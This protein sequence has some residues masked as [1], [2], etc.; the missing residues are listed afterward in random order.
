MRMVAAVNTLVKTVYKGAYRD[1]GYKTVGRKT[2]LPT[3]DP[4]CKHVKFLCP[5]D[6]LSGDET[7]WKCPI[8]K[9]S[10]KP[11][12]KNMNMNKSSP[13]Y[14]YGSNVMFAGYFGKGSDFDSSGARR[15]GRNQGGR[16]MSNSSRSSKG[17]KGKGGKGS[18]SNR[19]LTWAPPMG[20]IMNMMRTKKMSTNG[21]P[22]KA[23]A[24]VAFL[25]SFHPQCV[26]QGPPSKPTAP[27][28]SI[29]APSPSY[30]PTRC[31]DET[32]L[33]F[34]DFESGS[35]PEW[36]IN[37]VESSGGFTSFLGRLGPKD[38]TS[39]KFF[40]IPVASSL[41]I[42][43]DFYEIDN[44][45]DPTD[46]FF[47]YISDQK[48]DFGNFKASAD[49]GKKRGKTDCG[50]TWTMESK[51]SPK[52]IGFRND[53][54]R[55]RR[56]QIHRVVAIVPSSCSVYNNGILSI[57]FEALT[58][59]SVNN[60]AAG[61]DNLRI[62]AQNPCGDTPAP[63]SGGSPEGTPM[64]TSV[65]G[66]SIRTDEPTG[67]PTESPTG[68]PTMVPTASPTSMPT[69]SPTASP[70]S[71]PTGSPTSSPTLNP[72][73][74][75]TSS[76]TVSPTALPTMS[77]TTSPITSPTESPTADPTA[78]PTKSPT[79]SPTSS[80]TASPTSSPTNSPTGSPTSSPTEIPRNAA[81]TGMV[82]DNEDNPIEGAI[83]VLL[84][85]SGSVINVAT[86][87]EDGTYLFEDLPAGDY[88][89][90]ETNPVLYPL[91][92]DDYDF[93]PDGDVADSDRT[94]D[95]EI[96]VT[97]TPG[98]LDADNDF[99]DSKLEDPPTPSTST[100]PPTGSPTASPTLFP[101][102]SPTAFPTASPTSS[103]TELLRNAA[104][105]GI[106][107]DDEGKPLAGAII[108]LLDE[109][110]SV[111]NAATTSKDGTYLFEDLPAGEY[112]VRETNPVLYPLN[113]DDYDFDPDGDV[114]DSDRT[115]DNK[116]AVTLTPGELDAENDFV[117]S[118]GDETGP[119][120]PEQRLSQALLPVRLNSCPYFVTIASNYDQ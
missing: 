81:I 61:V 4:A 99:V 103:P 47:A 88:T 109:S 2:V 16:R 35:A 39:K 79:A 113:V 96:A 9:A 84:N 45:E 87:T 30:E 106:V 65:P 27:T 48:L 44:W 59:E 34:E 116:I 33:I 42:S 90:R 86:T 12:S 104:I 57:A 108:V 31:V 73:A 120:V 19:A 117:D 14:G 6:S 40:N 53:D 58:N 52:Q 18:R 17:S 69:S 70:T 7:L 8:K 32:L 63:F 98:E 38:L 3:S 82:R 112:T 75:P 25:P 78:S 111:I 102:V 91:N 5:G 110:G 1:V 54:N 23:G 72:T 71:S 13:I 115:V 107:R 50:I 101:T 66:I 10:N 41:K 85:D 94:V 20:M 64:T 68:S 97:L 11:M 28:V 37:R 76:P 89:V 83:I 119:P 36:S 77:P 67:A 22:V 105:S 24:E 56:D 26:T 46:C 60:E 118:Q 21:R 51:D 100:E 55:F 95:N 74:S 49:E 43:F 62:V 29:P 15:N 80:P 92:V 114:A 93:D